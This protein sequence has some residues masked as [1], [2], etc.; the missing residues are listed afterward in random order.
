MLYFLINLKEFI[1]W[2]L[3]FKRW[4]GKLGVFFFIVLNFGIIKKTLFFPYLLDQKII[5]I[6]S[7]NR[8]IIDIIKKNGMNNI[9]NVTV[10]TISNILLII[11]FFNN[12]FNFDVSIYKVPYIE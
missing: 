7:D 2:S 1:I 10:K 3:S 4:V 11:Y 8:M 9:N 12:L 6:P 5:G